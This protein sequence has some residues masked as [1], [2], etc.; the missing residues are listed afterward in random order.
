MRA[1]NRMSANR[2]SVLEAR[3]R[4]M[5]HAPTP[6]E[7]KLFRALRGRQLGVVFRRQVPLL[8][9][10]IADLLAP[11]VRLIVEID[12]ECHARRCAADARR[13][14]A[15]EKAGYRVLRLPAELIIRELPV[16]LERIALALAG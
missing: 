15:L 13:N 1:L 2:H 4:E 10:Y 5:R 14:H 9:R 3:A 11:E 12:G 8:G 7:E 16:A 6:S